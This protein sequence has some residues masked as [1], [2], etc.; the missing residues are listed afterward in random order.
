VFALLLDLVLPRGKESYVVWRRLVAVL[1]NKEFFA[2]DGLG[3]FLVY[4]FS[5]R[6]VLYLQIC[7]LVII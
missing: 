3:L 1:C 7:V 2:F 5:T 4:W 6:L